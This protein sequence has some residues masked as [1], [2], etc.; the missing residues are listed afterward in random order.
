MLRNRHPR[1]ALGGP[2]ASVRTER[3]GGAEAGMLREGA[4]PRG[5]AY[6]PLS[7]SLLPL[8]LHYLL[9][10]RPSFPRGPRAGETRGVKPV[11]KQAQSPASPFPGPVPAPQLGPRRVMAAAPDAAS[12]AEGGGGKGGGARE[13]GE[14]VPRAVTQAL[15]RPGRR[16]GGRGR[17][18]TV[19]ARGRWRV[20]RAGPRRSGSPPPPPPP[21]PYHAEPT[22]RAL[23]LCPIMQRGRRRRLNR[24]G[25]ESERGRRGGRKKRRG[26]P[27]SPE[28]A[29]LGPPLKEGGRALSA[30]P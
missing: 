4:G 13:G 1:S 25:R 27:R 19:A 26:R 6:A 5:G 14:R 8:R 29:E 15:S 23:C 17:R 20:A 12:F 7:L 11:G 18:R 3:H 30:G 24:K 16:D 21:S 9:L 2:R 22:S 10:A 28:G